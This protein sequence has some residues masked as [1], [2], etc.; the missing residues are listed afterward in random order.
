MDVG[1]LWCGKTG[2]HSSYE[3]VQIFLKTEKVLLF[4]CS[5]SL[6]R[7]RILLFSKLPTCSLPVI[8]PLVLRCSDITTFD[9]PHRSVS[10]DMS[11]LDAIRAQ[12]LAQL[13]GQQGGG[14]SPG[15]Q[16]PAGMTPQGGPGQA[17]EDPA[18]KAQAQQQE[19]EMR[20]TLMGQI[21]ASDARERCR[22]FDIGVHAVA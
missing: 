12:R 4:D 11:D 22:S 19:E 2:N 17:E 8:S 18:A 13:R 10:H 1:Y 20:R 3:D 14:A 16:L 7:R 15:F 21:L 6:A 5:Y 9:T